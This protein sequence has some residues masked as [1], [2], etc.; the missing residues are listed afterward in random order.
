MPNLNRLADRGLSGSIASTHP[1]EPVPAWASFATGHGPGQLGLTGERNR[2]VKRTRQGRELTYGEGPRAS[3]V[4]LEAPTFWQRAA[5]SGQRVAL[6]GVPQTF[7]VEPVNGSLVAG[8]PAPSPEAAFT[9]PPELAD[10]IDD[11]VD[12]AFFADPRAGSDRAERVELARRQLDQRF[13]VGRHLAEQGSELFVLVAQGLRA[14][15]EAAWS[16]REAE[17]PLHE[18]DLADEVA[19]AYRRVDDHLGEL[20]AAL[21]DDAG[22]LVVSDAGAQGARGSLRLNAWLRRE[23]FLC[24]TSEPEDPVPFSPDRVDWSATQAWATGGA[25]GRVHLNVEG[26]EPEGI[27]DPLDYEQARETIQEELAASELDIDVR[28]PQRAYEG[29]RVD[30]APDLFVT[31]EGLRRRCSAAVGHEEGQGGPER[32]RDE[33]AP[34]RQ[35]SFVLAEPEHRYSGEVS[36]ARLVDV[37]ATVL[38]L[39][40][41]N[42]E[43]LNGRP[44]QPDGAVPDG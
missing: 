12:E 31:V 25:V 14:I 35:A 32:G 29:P 16:T 10:E 44:I 3:S 6:V 20:R 11:L 36:E 15:E 1:P 19:A 13:A 30:E 28:K 9:H 41:V 27:V 18:E 24:L 33:A 2:D 7:P 37:A 39:L 17:H 26:R 22:V 40:D 4:D 38:E 23:G 42:V 21:P 43:A 8:R 34:T 5:E